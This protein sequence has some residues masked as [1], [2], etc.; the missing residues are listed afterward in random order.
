M[1]QE[2]F[3]DGRRYTDKALLMMAMRKHF[4]DPPKAQRQRAILNSGNWISLNT[5]ASP[6]QATYSLTLHYCINVMPCR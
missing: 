1:H 3:W 2:S 6:L 5:S 4:S